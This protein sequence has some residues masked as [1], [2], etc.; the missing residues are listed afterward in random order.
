MLRYMMNVRQISQV[1]RPVQLFTLKNL[2]KKARFV[3]QKRIDISCLKVT[4]F[5]KNVVK[6]TIKRR[7]VNNTSVLRKFDLSLSRHSE[8]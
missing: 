2:T 8:R 7:L 3:N 1:A 6:S 4:I 5:V